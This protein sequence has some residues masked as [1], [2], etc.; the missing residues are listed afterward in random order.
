MNFILFVIIMYH[1]KYNRS[2]VKYIKINALYT[3]TPFW[4]PNN[5]SN[6]TKG[7]N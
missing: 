5:E 4:L 7:D 6:P 3:N 2:L 1:Y